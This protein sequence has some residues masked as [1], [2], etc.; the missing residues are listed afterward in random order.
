MDVNLALK[1]FGLSEKESKTYLALLPHGTSTLQNI[2]QHLDFP[3]T[4][5]YNSL[6]YLIE[7]GL[8]SKITIQGIMHY[9]ATDPQKFVVIL[10]QKKKLV[11]A[12]I[13]QLEML[14]KTQSAISRVELYEGTKGVLSIL[15]DV[16]SQQQQTY[17]LGSYSRSLEILKHLPS[18]V[19][20]LRLEKKIP[21]QIVIDPYD[22]PSFHTKEYRSITQ[23]RF[24][25]G[26]KEFPCMLFIYGKKVAIYTVHGDLIG[27]IIENKEISIAM[28]MLFDLYWSSATTNK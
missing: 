11:L 21:A 3:R 15:S 7:R 18:Q 16:F 28:K 25:K 17:Y 4:T 19:R 2:A 10:D 6:N 8:V 1:E 22:E 13:P 26:L 5:V 23:M 12:A 27:V 9:Q 20:T 14:Q 24:H